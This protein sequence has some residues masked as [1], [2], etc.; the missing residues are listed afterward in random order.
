MINKRKIEMIHKVL[1]II[2]S[3]ISYLYITS[4]CV[5]LSSNDFSAGGITTDA[6]GSSFDTLLSSSS[7]LL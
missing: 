2:I 1:L 4:F 6:N 3:D 7:F 5:Q